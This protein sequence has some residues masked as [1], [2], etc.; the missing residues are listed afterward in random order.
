MKLLGEIMIYTAYYLVTSGNIV[1][2]PFASVDA[3][4]D[5]KK[6]YSPAARPLLHIVRSTIESDPV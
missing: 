6:V 2:G 5:G 4:V 1:A 3:A